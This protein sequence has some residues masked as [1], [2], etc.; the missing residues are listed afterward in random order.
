MADWTPPEV[1]QEPQSFVPPE[2]A[3]ESQPQP[4]PQPAQPVE[5]MTGQSMNRAVA[6][7]PYEKETLSRMDQSFEQAHPILSNAAL[8]AEDLAKGAV[9]GAASLPAQ[10]YRAARDGAFTEALRT[11]LPMGKQMAE[12]VQ[13]PLGTRESF[14]GIGNILFMSAPGLELARELRPIAK[15]PVQLSEVL[16]PKETL[17]SV[18]Q[19][20]AGLSALEQ[21]EPNAI[22]QPET[23]QPNGMRAEPEVPQETQKPAASVGGEGVPEVRQGTEVPGSQTPQVETAYPSLTAEDKTKLESMTPEQAN[24]EA[25]DV[26][27]NRDDLIKSGATQGSPEYQRANDYAS[28][29]L[30]KAQ[31]AGLPKQTIA[32]EQRPL[33]PEPRTFSL[34]STADEFGGETTP[35]S[36]YVM[37]S[38]GLLSKHGATKAGK[39]EGNEALWDD[40]PSL[41]HPTHNKIYQPSGEMPD[42]MAQNLFDQGLISDPSVGAMNRALES[43][44]R[45]SR[46]SV[47]TA[48]EQGK[49]VAEQ[50]KQSKDFSAALHDERDAGSR[51]IS[52]GNLNVGDQVKVGTESFKVTDVDPDTFDVTLEDGKKFGVQTVSDN[53]VI[54][55]EHTPVVSSEQFA[56]EAG[57]RPVSKSFPADPEMNRW[58]EGSKV[59]NEKGDPMIVYHGG[60]K[61]EGKFKSPAFFTES[62]HGASWYAGEKGEGNYRVQPHYLSIKNPLDITTLKGNQELVKI[63]SD[64][65]VKI[66]SDVLD[67]SPDKS[68]GWQFQSDE[69]SK[70]SPYDGSNPADLVYIPKV[71]EALKKAGYDGLQVSDVLERSEIPTW[72]AFDAEQIRPYKGKAKSSPESVPVGEPQP[73][74]ATARGTAPAEAPEGGP[75]STKNAYTEQQRELRGLP[76]AEQAAKRSFGTVW[77]EAAAQEKTDPLIGRRLV[78]ELNQ[79]ARPVNDVENA[80]LLRREIEAQKEHNDA[81]D[82]VNNATTPEDLTAARSR[83]QSARND[84]QD[85]YDATKRAGTKSGQALSARRMMANEDYSLAR[86]E[87]RRRAANDG[88]PLDENQL[89]EVKELHDKIADLQSK[90]N[91]HEVA[92]AFDQEFKKLVDQS[93]TEAKAARTTTKFTDFMDRKADEAR[94]RIAERRGRLT[95]GFDPTS[96]ADEAVIGASHIAKGLT[97]FA[98]WSAQMA[99]E[100]GDQIRPFLQDIWERA[101]AFHDANA[102][103]YGDKALQRYKTYLGK[104][105]EQIKAK[106]EAGDFTKAQRQKTKLDVEAFNM[107]ADL[108]KLKNQFEKGVAK[109]TYK[110][111]TPAQKFWDHF[112]GVERAMKLSG[113][114]VFGK[115]GVAAT[116]REGGISTAESLAGYGV[117]KLFPKLAEGTRYGAGLDAVLRAEVKAKAAMFTKGIADAA[118]NVMGKETGLDAISG[119]KIRPDFWYNRIGQMHAAIKAPVKRAEFT[120]SLE[121]RMDAAIR[122]G[123]DINHPEVMT[124]LANEAV[125]DANRGIF[126]QKTVV[127]NFFSVLERQHPTAGRVS[128]FLFPVVK[129]PVNLFKELVTYHAGA[130]VGAAKIGMAYWKGIESMPALER[131][132]IIRQFVKGSV[133]GA[134]LLWGYYNSDKV[135]KFFA[136]APQWFHHT[137]IAMVLNEGSYLKKLE[138]NDPEKKE[139]AKELKYMAKTAIP[140]AYTITDAA[141]MLGQHTSES[142]LKWIHNMTQ[143]TVVPQLVTQVAKATDKPGT[144]PSNLGQKPTYRKPKDTAEAIKLGIPG[145]RQTVPPYAPKKPSHQSHGM[146]PIRR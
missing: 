102:K 32:A 88:R 100:F 60:P 1:E 79:K 117:S 99:R 22:V 69:I 53:E 105:T 15:P 116:I 73:S 26:M 29:V 104:Q 54:Y 51:A 103:E 34:P 10:L 70:H 72:V 3:A 27:Q 75:V 82:A 36:A 64:A 28:A 5:Q 39:I 57:V 96:I 68:I 77:D 113:P 124:R 131:E 81:I 115:L 31:Q 87:A 142:V 143:S 63:A 25:A 40:R 52:A 67:W 43:E 12:D 121:L 133:G 78:E 89:A 62:A 20:N 122:S 13:S 110:N 120:R 109:E 126:Q 50:Q 145:L 98:D 38:G 84:L 128:R 139:G 42:V 83:L 18:E 6:A 41:K 108:Q 35:V 66:D 127:S 65:G 111:R 74:P 19:T 9:E 76:E 135:K 130:P 21:G 58:F 129:I 61:F 55:G 80:H 16:Y 48:R 37:D 56:P 101:K 97:K 33:P 4:T 14:R 17:P 118:Q 146:T 91:A 134:A 136:N 138:G 95:T 7:L 44:S 112:V 49:T 8:A 59:V 85:V 23:A 71:R 107:R 119:T 93:R 114:E 94:Q 2:V 92:R 140:F 137:P 106:I 125:M 90:L 24:L 144:F 46:S 11:A 30:D 47:K 123:E 45:T 132:A 141:E 86:M